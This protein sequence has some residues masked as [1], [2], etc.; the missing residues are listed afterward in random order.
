MRVKI[1]EVI[2][3]SNDNPIMVMLDQGNKEYISNL[4]KDG[5]SNVC[6]FPSGYKKEVI[7]QF[8]DI[9]GKFESEVKKVEKNTDN[10]N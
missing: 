3:N 10:S 5:T 1:G 2:Y 6:F 7:E 4:S 8:M 9:N